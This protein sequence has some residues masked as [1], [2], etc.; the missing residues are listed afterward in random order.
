MEV[1]EFDEV[2][3]D[4]TDKADAGAS[5]HLSL[6]GSESPTAD[7]CDSSVGEASL[8]FC[9]DAGEEDLTGVA[10]VA[11]GHDYWYEHLRVA[12]GEGKSEG[13]SSFRGFRHLP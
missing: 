9:A 2:T 3:I 11:R 8:S 6:G 5:E 7:D 13:P 4:D 1:G 12:N 10:V